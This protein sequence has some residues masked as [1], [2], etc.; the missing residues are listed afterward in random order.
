MRERLGR[1]VESEDVAAKSS[2]EHA[3]VDIRA[4]TFAMLDNLTSGR[5]GAQGDSLLEFGKVGR[6]DNN[7]S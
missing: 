3:P 5:S 6:D 7:F 2:Q 1:D 4:R